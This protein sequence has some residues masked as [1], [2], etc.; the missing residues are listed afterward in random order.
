MSFL[1]KDI[2]IGLVGYEGRMGQ[3]IIS[4]LKERNIKIFTNG[5]EI[6]GDK[7]KIFDNSDVVIDFSS[8]DGLKDCLKLAEIKK[9]P[10]VSGSTPMTEDIMN[11]IKEVSR[12]CKVCW[13][14]NMSIGI[15]ITKKISSL[16]GKWLLDYDCEIF[17][18]HHNKKKDAPSGT[19]IMI[20]KEIA[21]NREQKFSDVAVFDRHEK[22]SG[23]RIQGQI[24]FSSARGGRVF[25][26]HEIMFF[27]NDDEITIS[28]RAY[29][30]RLFAVG[31]VECAIKLLDKKENGFYSVE[32]LLLS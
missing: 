23:E 30:R 27:G 31:A 5:G 8:K 22:Q 26:E 10:L 9:V 14:A 6:N 24:G 1:N 18:K 32:D 15:A 7:N 13:S 21:K 3:E 20:G 16:V 19:A 17:E 29:N 28:H 4:V 11:D 25:G 12:N 2:C